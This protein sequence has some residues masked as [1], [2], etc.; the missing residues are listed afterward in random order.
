MMLLH[1]QQSAKAHLSD[2]RVGALFMEP[3]TGKSFIALNLAMSFAIAGKRVLLMD[4]DLRR[5]TLSK[6]IGF[7]G[8]GIS[9]MLYQ[10]A[11]NENL[12]IQKNYFFTHFDIMPVGTMI[13]NPSE[14]LMSE[15]LISFLKKMRTKYDY[16]FIDSNPVNIVADASIVGQLVDLSI[17]VVRENFTY[18]RRLSEI[19][20]MYHSGK[21]KNMCMVLNCSNTEVSSDEYDAYN[22]KDDKEKTILPKISFPK[23]PKRSE[24]LTE[25]K[26][27]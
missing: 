12:F 15:R 20:K 14:L 10:E 21:F 17:F 8:Y 24:L 25:G 2:W 27:N 5:A 19:K 26:K 7:P 1:N 13:S 11:E 18:R 16:I 9:N 4:L 3:G 6:R 23:L 22:Y